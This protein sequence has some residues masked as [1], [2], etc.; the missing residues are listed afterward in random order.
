MRRP[1]ETLYEDEHLIIVNKSPGLLTIPDRYQHDKENLSGLLAEKFGEIFIVHRL[2]RETSGVIMFAKNAAM[3]KQLSTLFESG[4]IDK[5]YMAI[6]KGSPAID[7]GIVETHIAP[8]EHVK[9]KMI[10]FKKGKWS[11]TG[12]R[13][14]E[15]YSDKF[16]LVELKLFTGRTHQIRVHM[17]YLGNPL[18]VDRLYT[19]VE[20]FYLSEI[21]KRKYRSSA[22]HEERPL[23]A[24][25]SLHASSVSFSHPITKETIEVEAALP[26]DMRAVITQMRKVIGLVEA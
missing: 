20:A 11:K 8:S 7:E 14:K 17:E 19:G 4:D 5:R 12:F 21:K 1:Y 18:L 13:I 2:D 22:D 15:N 16:S 23:I 6:L 10:V 9:G 24:R 25:H 3:H 26:K